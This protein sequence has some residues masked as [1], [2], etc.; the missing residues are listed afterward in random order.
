L[1]LILLERLHLD[2]MPGV[3]HAC[4]VVITGDVICDY[5]SSSE[6]VRIGRER[7]VGEYDT[8]HGGHDD[9]R[10]SRARLTSQKEKGGGLSCR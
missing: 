3:H 7:G 5:I 8:Y 9:R 6:I 10:R 4:M 1:H 2:D